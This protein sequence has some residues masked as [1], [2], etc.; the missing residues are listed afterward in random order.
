MSGGARSYV[1][2][3]DGILLRYDGVHFTQGAADWVQP[4]LEA[5]LARVHERT[6]TG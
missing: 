5:Q 6:E 1:A 3:V 2:A 4:W